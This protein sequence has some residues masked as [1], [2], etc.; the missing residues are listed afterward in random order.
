MLKNSCYVQRLTVFVLISVWLS[1][2]GNCGDINLVRLGPEKSINNEVLRFSLD[3]QVNHRMSKYGIKVYT[4][5]FFSCCIVGLGIKGNLKTLEI[6]WFRKLIF[7]LIVC[8]Y[9]YILGVKVYVCIYMYECNY[10]ALVLSLWHSRYLFWFIK[11]M[12]SF[13][14]LFL[15][16]F[17]Y[18]APISHCITLTFNYWTIFSSSVMMS[19]LTLGF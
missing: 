15:H 8:E 14:C 7:L 10:T 12:C 9:V 6:V 16:L 2:T 18:S 5:L 17:T 4:N 11:I 13:G 3:S 19:F 1:S